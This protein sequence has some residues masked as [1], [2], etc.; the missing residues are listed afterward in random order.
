MISITQPQ[1]DLHLQPHE[2][3]QL[4]DADS[5]MAIECK[6]GIVWITRTGDSHDYMLTPGDTYQPAK[7]GKIVIEAMREAQICLADESGKNRF[8]RLIQNN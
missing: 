7:H 1:I 5:D 8:A 4:S 6:Q 3:V 2:L